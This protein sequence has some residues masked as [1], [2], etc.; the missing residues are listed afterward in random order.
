MGWSMTGLGLLRRELRFKE[1]SIIS[2]GT[3]VAGYL[4]V[5]VGLA[6]LGA[7]VWSLV[8]GTIVSTA[9]QAVWQYL[10]LRH[11]VRP[12]RRW[13]PY[14][15]V[16]GYGAKLSGAHLMD[17][18]GGNLDTLTV[19]RIASTAVLGQYSRAYYL[20]FQP[21][22][23]YLS[24]ALTTVLFSALSRIQ[25]DTA[26]L[27]RAF[28]GVMA[29]GNML[30]FPLCTGIAVAS[31][32][33]VQVVLGPQWN[34]AIGLVPWFA[35]AGGCHVASQ[36]SQSLAEVRAELNRSIGV[37][38][39]YLVVLAGCLG[40]AF[41]YRSEGVWVIA[42]AVAAAEV[43]R[44]LGYVVLVKRVLSLP[45]AGVLDAHL[46][47]AASSGAVALAIAAAGRLT[48]GHWPVLLVLTAEMVAA[49]LALILA[50]RFLPMTTVRTELRLRL[51]GAGLLGADGG[52]RA[53]LAQLFLGP[54]P[55]AT[56]PAT[57][58][59]GGRQTP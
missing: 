15:E 13:A 36:L 43:I 21:L 30:L 56:D 2:V 32:E 9:S 23:N 47:A 25:Q 55:A 11:P 44:Y 14:R 45:A 27:R 58:S 40:L 59:A 19:A 29:L 20:V 10:V 5:G 26:R 46:P 51:G 3:Y 33:L 57:G 12:V 28:L 52:R 17:Y 8:F 37:Q 7:G 48:T 16:T 4:V 18:V 41:A 39:A 35:V 6:A 34:L 31:R 38:A 1:L 54:P 24:Q 49:A 22:G 50:I 42:A 53:R